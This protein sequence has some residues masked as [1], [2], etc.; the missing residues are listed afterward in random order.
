QAALP[1]L[2]LLYYKAR[3]YHPALGRFLQ[4]DPI[5]YEDDVNLYAY[6]SNDPLNNVDPTGRSCSNNEKTGTTTCT[7]E[8]TGSRIPFKVTFPTPK[9]WPSKIDSSQRNHHEYDK[10]VS[11]GKGSAGKADALRQGTVKDPTPGQDKPATEAGVE[12]D[13]TPQAGFRQAAGQ[14]GNNKVI[15]YLRKDGNGN[16]MVVNVTLPGHSLFPGYVA[17]LV[18]IENGQAVI[19]NVGEGTGWLQSFGPLSDRL[20]NNVWIQQSQEIIDAN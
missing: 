17:R 1:D 10:P 7:K 14:L 4:T 5:G 12:N 9:G 8:V 2:G 6:V 15:S 11:A 19:H 13:A 16:T 18:T 3:F 20:I